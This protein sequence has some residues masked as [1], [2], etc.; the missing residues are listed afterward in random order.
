MKR[1]AKKCEYFWLHFANVFAKISEA[2]T[3]PKFAKM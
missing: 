2:K 3:K 1:F